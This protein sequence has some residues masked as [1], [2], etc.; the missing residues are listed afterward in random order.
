MDLL[1]FKNKKVL[2][3]GCGFGT[4]I[5]YLYKKGIDVEGIE[6]DSKNVKLINSEI[7][8]KTIKTGNY[9]EMNVNKKYDIIILRHVFEHFYDINTVISN[10]EKNLNKGGILFLNVPNAGNSKILKFSI[11]EHPHSF[12]F[13]K[14][15]F[16]LIFNQFKFRPILIQTYS[17]RTKNKLKLL[18][19]RFLRISN[20]KKD[21]VKNSEFLIGMLKK[22]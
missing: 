6:I 21:S 22:I 10:L 1:K 13:T 5:K 4:S 15:S 2:E 7:K 11:D 8:K 17:W 3:I 20:L 14:K 18:I 16:K 12:H 9:E 19:M